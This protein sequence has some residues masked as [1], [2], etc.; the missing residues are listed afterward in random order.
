MPLTPLHHPIAYFVYK[1][2]KRFSLPGLVVGC[3]FPDL[4][5]PVMM[6]L[7]ETQVPNH[8]VLHSL[9]GSAT[10]GTLLA[11]IFTVHVYPPLVNHLFHVD[12]KRVKSK[13]KLSF[14]VFFSVLVG[15]LSHVLLDVTNHPYSPVFWPFLPATAASNPIYFALGEPLGYL[16]VQIIMAAL[17]AVLVVVKLR[18]L[19]EELLVG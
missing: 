7:F 15:N 4:E 12:K 1:L 16:W 9:L 14:T 19:C 8:L 3:M 13:C 11:L 17:V 10:I 2:D 6:L 18:N 5:I